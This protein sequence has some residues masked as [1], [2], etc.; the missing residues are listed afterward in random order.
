MLS[1]SKP[2]PSVSLP[3]LFLALGVGAFCAFSYRRGE[4]PFEAPAGRVDTQHLPEVEAFNARVAK[5][6][7]AA[8]QCPSGVEVQV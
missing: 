7:E 4:W 8:A 6:A 2:I 3:Q 5:H 1:Q